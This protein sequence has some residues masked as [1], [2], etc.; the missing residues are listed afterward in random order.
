MTPDIR[1]AALCS[2][3]FL[4]LTTGRAQEAPK[5]ET[6]AQEAQ[7][8]EAQAQPESVKPPV[9]EQQIIGSIDVG[10]RWILGQGGSEEVYRSIVNLG[11]GPKLL[12]SEL[13]IRRPN[14]RFYD[15]IDARASSWGGDPYNTARLEAARAGV[16]AF[17]F[18]YRNVSYFNSIPSFANPFLEQGLLFSQRSFDMAR[19]LIDTELELRPRARFSPFLAFYHSSGL[20][21]GVTTFV[22][23]GNEFAVS[24]RLRDATD[25]YRGGLR[26]NFTKLNLTLEQGGTTFKDDQQVSFADGV[27]PG[28]RS[29]PL[30]GQDILLRDLRQA[31]GARGSGIFNRAVLEGRPWS[32]VHFTGQFLYS[33]PS[34]DVD[35]FQQNNGNFLLLETFQVFTGQLDRSLSEANRPRTSGSWT[36][37]VRPAQRL[38]I[39]QSWFTDRFHIAGGSFLA[40]ALEAPSLRFFQRETALSSR[41]VLNFNQ[42]QVDAIVDVSPLLTLRGGHRYEWGDATSLTGIRLLP[43]GEAAQLKRHVALAGGS[44]RVRANFDLN[45]DL[46]ASTGDRTFFRTD[47]ADYQRAKLRGRYRPIKALAL[48]GSF[49][50]LNN[51]NPAPGVSFDYQSRQTSLALFFTPGDGA[52]WSLLLDYMRGTVRST[53]PFLAPQDRTGEISRYRDDGHF[54]GASFEIR[55]WR[56]SRVNLGGSFAASAGSRPTRYYQPHGRF[57]LPVRGKLAWTTEWRW[58]GFT[59]RRYAF[60]N[61]H[62]NLF[63][64]GFRL[65]L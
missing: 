19:R 20:G 55:L 65:G 39:V 58:F 43:G 21:R 31:Y 11:E 48:T 46:E 6:P 10:Y 60:E 49:A 14:G 17:R 54:G 59:E 40:S 30:L 16:Y 7:A 56:G 41:L 61:F 22:A 57:L 2:L 38:R 29:V 13:S 62:T 25:S 28:N 26:V 36:T 23:D 63:S 32:R 44:L 5:K 64:T 35:Y 50:I 33:K 42:H 24:T 1:V 47:L 37:E 34:L 12:G 9:P 27:N 18:D 52:R 4:A 51:Q 3:A 8:K 45:A 53:I 15:R